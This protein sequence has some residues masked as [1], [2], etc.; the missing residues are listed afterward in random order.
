M[1]CLWKKPI[2]FPV[3]KKW[4]KGQQDNKKL[5]KTFKVENT[6]IKY[7]FQHLQINI[8]FLFEWEEKSNLMSYLST[9]QCK[10]CHSLKNG[11]LQLLNGLKKWW[12]FRQYL[13]FKRIR[14]KHRPSL[15]SEDSDLEFDSLV[16]LVNY[17]TS[18]RWFVFFA[19]IALDSND[20]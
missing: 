13:D 7:P 19:W 15:F 17:Y 5:C 16:S 20:L 8:L 4:I 11:S 1:V 12:K 14:I 10:F 9:I 18:N 2:K 3:N 6:I